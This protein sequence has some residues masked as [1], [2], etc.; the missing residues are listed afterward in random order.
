M[1][2]N[3]IY[4]NNID[5]SKNLNNFNLCMELLKKNKDLQLIGEGVLGQIFIASSTKCGSIVIKKFKNDNKNEYLYREVFFMLLIKNLILKNI[6]PN[7]IFLINK[8]NNLIV[9]EYAD[10]NISN[11]YKQENINLNK[12]FLYI[13]NFQ[14]LISILAIQ[15]MIFTVHNDLHLENI[16][17]KKINNDKIK[18]FEYNINGNKFY[19]PNNGYLFI[20]SDF[21]N[22]QSLLLNRNKNWFDYKVI[23]EMIINNEDFKHLK[24]IF[25]KNIQWY[26]LKNKK[27][28]SIDELFNLITN[29]DKINNYYNELIE[30]YKNDNKKI[31]EKMIIYT[32]SIN[33]LDYKQF[34]EKKDV[35]YYI[36]SDEFKNFIDNIYNANDDIFNIINNNFQNFKYLDKDKYSDNQIKKFYINYETFQK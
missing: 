5:N 36:Y 34:I 3:L 12:D 18:I 19:I 15:K 10:G 29:K 6:C 26:I 20:L 23:N 4:R 14:I 9:M 16:F 33:L 1:N 28:N 32:L 2:N 21:G 27:I 17:F 11:I 8:T 31:L 13:L 30:K 24:L 22:S 7:F 35:D 25:Y